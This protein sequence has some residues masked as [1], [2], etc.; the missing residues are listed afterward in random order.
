MRTD[1]D[2]AKKTNQTTTM[3]QMNEEAAE[4]EVEEKFDLS[5]IEVNAFHQIRKSLFLVIFKEATPDTD[6]DGDGKVDKWGDKKVG[7]EKMKWDDYVYKL[8]GTNNYVPVKYI[9]FPEVEISGYSET[10]DLDGGEGEF[11]VIV[12]RPGDSKY[13][14]E[15]GNPVG[16]ALSEVWKLAGD[17][18]GALGGVFREGGKANDEIKKS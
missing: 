16:K 13:P 3:T 1:P 17:A 14:I 10:L 8:L 4:K 15:M 2:I 6:T 12:K 11:T 5:K 9:Y 18:M 7:E